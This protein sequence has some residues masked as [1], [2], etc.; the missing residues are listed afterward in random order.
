MWLDELY[1]SVAA[2]LCRGNIPLV[3]RLPGRNEDVP[4]RIDDNGSA[5]VGTQHHADLQHAVDAVARDVP[6][7]S[8]GTVPVMPFDAWDVV[9]VAHPGLPA[10]RLSSHRV[11]PPGGAESE[12]LGP[13]LQQYWDRLPQQT[14]DIIYILKRPRAVQGSDLCASGLSLLGQEIARGP[15]LAADLAAYEQL[16]ET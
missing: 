4:L 2:G 5:T 15:P 1:P 14:R 11:S 16:S 6:G 8:S 10:Y 7:S 3:V 12:R 9:Y 13:L